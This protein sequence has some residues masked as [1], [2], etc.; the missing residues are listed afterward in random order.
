MRFRCQ[1]CGNYLDSD[2]TVIKRVTEIGTVC[3]EE[4]L[5]GDCFHSDEEETFY[6]CPECGR[7]DEVL[8][9]LVEVILLKFKEGDKVKILNAGMEDEYPEHVGKVGV[10]DRVDDEDDDYPYK[11]LIEVEDEDED[12][13][14]AEDGIE[15][16]PDG[17]TELPLDKPTDDPLRDLLREMSE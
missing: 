4:D 15:L 10:I 5:N 1:W 14:Y 13:W 16:A 7:S 9:N 3:L 11:V 17:Q 2:S 6:D 8:A 12:C